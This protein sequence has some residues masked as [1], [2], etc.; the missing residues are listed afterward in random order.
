MFINSP[1]TQN[2]LNIKLHKTN[3]NRDTI[4]EIF[5]IKINIVKN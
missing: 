4:F 5:K 2:I 3:Y 1:K